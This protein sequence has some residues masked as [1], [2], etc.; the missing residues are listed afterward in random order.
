[1]YVAVWMDMWIYCGKMPVLLDPVMASLSDCKAFFFNTL[2]HG[3]T[4]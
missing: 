4:I 2:M 3:K 1:M